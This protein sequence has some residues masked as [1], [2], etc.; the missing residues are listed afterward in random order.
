M[1]FSLYCIKS[2][3]MQKLSNK[4]AAFL[5]LLLFNIGESGEGYFMDEETNTMDTSGSCS[6]LQI[7][8][9]MLLETSGFEKDPGYD[10]EGMPLI[11]WPGNNT[12]N[13]FDDPNDFDPEEWMR[14][15]N[16]DE[17]AHHEELSKIDPDDIWK[18]YLKGTIQ[19]KLT[20]CFNDPNGLDISRLLEII[21]QVN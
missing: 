21:D 13:Q 19:E 12:D 8:A 4:Q 14:N 1:G 9:E 3:I 7:V 10:N 15:P 17:S 6:H 5:Y 20:Q 11:F 18:G 2:I 16:F